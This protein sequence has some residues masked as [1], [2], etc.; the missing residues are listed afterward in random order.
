MNAILVKSIFVNVVFFIFI[1][2]LSSCG[3][4]DNNVSN[5]PNDL[6]SQVQGKYKLISFSGFGADTSNDYIMVSK[7]NPTTIYYQEHFSFRLG[8]WD[9]I[10][11][12]RTNGKISFSYFFTDGKGVCTF[13]NNKLEFGFSSKYGYTIGYVAK[14]I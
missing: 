1:L 14:R 13:Q 7:I 8:N 11:L 9:Y 2:S 5:D 10:P 6:A 3:N 4:S 12:T